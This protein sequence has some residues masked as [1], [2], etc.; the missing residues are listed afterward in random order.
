MAGPQVGERAPDFTLPGTGDKTYSLADYKGK[1]VVL[2]IYPGDN[3]LVCTKQLCTYRDEFPTFE[4]LDA[5]V[6]GIS[7]QDVDSHEKFAAKHGFTF[8]LLADTDKSVIK[9]YGALGPIGFVKRSIFMIDGEGIVR[10]RHVA[11]TGVTYKRPDELARTLK[12]M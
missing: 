8:P 10:Y 12:D 5:V 4:G 9:A 3:T 7:P 2:A 11:A 6:L 1:K